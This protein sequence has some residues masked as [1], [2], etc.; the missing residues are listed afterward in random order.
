M[1]V[2]ASSNAGE[3]DIDDHPDVMR[4]MLLQPRAE[5]E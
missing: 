4:V 5:S 1:R 2:C 3:I